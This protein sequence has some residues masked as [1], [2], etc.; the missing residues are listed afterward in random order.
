MSKVN[1][2]TGKR[3]GFLTVQSF[4]GTVRSKG[5][6]TSAYWKCLCDCGNE[7]CVC[8]AHLVT[9]I[10][11]SCGCY[12]KMMA[13]RQTIKHGMSDT[14]IYNIWDKMC[15]R[16]SSEKDHAYVYYGGRGISVCEEWKGENG[17]ENFYSWAISNGYTEQLTIDR[18]D[19]NGNYEP[20]N[21]RWVTMQVQ[22][23]NK[24]NCHYV[25]YNGERITLSEFERRTGI[26]R[27]NV[28]SYEKYYGDTEKAVEE[29]LQRQ[30]EKEL[31]GRQRIKKLFRKE[32]V[33][34]AD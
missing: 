24:R 17:F 14:R 21:C 34:S 30:K 5:G 25:N 33:V 16:C 22:N 3:F 2:L 27:V 4:A 6:H 26:S 13:G 7:V 12:R 31:L 1:D 19:N 10:T 11:K 29:L 32:V 28:R 8:R 15:S 18:I 9:G 23:D 20:S